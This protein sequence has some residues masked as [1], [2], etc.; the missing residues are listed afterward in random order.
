MIEAAEYREFG[1]SVLAVPEVVPRLMRADTLIFDI[2][3]VIM[4][5]T[6]SIRV[7]GCEAVRF[8]LTQLL[9]WPASR[10]AAK[11][12]APP[13]RPDSSGPATFVEP[14]EVD[15]YR[16]ADGFNDDWEIAGL[17]V[18]MYLVKAELIGSRD[19]GALRAA[20]PTIA[21]LAQAARESRGGVPF[22]RQR[23][24]A[25]LPDSAARERAL[26][27]WDYAKI[28]QVFQE[29]YAGESHCFAFY[30]YH[31]RY[32]HAP[33][34]VALDRPLIR[35]ESLPPKVTK[36]GIYSGR[37]WQETRAALEMAGIADLFT[38]ESVVVVDD[39]MVKPDPRGLAVLVQRMNSTAAVF[40]GDM[41]DDREA[42]RRYR[43]GPAASAADD[44]P[45]VFDCLVLSGPMGGRSDEEIRAAG[46]DVVAP[47]VNA[48]MRWWAGLRRA[49]QS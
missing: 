21:E 34:L 15:L 31:P 5:V 18:L 10:G 23:L 46:A 19:V 33:G 9:G 47:D 2:D 44:S 30:G 39:G 11:R 12:E 37:T 17:N 6:R 25:M 22:V 49:G 40:V 3:G 4:D 43:R 1:G 8:Y 13:W 7:V 27:Q 35:R 16:L 14:E 38:R 32:V 41:P 42:V 26:A 28:V 48:F 29:L 20:S 45:E 36:Y 24:L